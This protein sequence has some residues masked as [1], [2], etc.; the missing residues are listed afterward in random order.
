VS[1]KI[2][3]YKIGC[4]QCLH[5]RMRGVI[6]V[7]SGGAWGFLGGAKSN[8]QLR[9]AKFNTLQQTVKAQFS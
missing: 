6:L 7:I 9:D 5:S 4:E 2:P 8:Y 1:N 3:T